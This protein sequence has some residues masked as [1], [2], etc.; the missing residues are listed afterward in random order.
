M[1]G[2]CETPGECREDVDGAD[3]IFHDR[4]AL[5]MS[6]HINEWKGLRGEDTA[7]S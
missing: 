1:F 4:D 5:T 2:E 6:L 7:P 3:L